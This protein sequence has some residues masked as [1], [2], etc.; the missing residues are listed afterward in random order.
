MEE[1]PS[2]PLGFEE[3]LKAPSHAYSEDSITQDLR[4]VGSLGSRTGKAQEGA[5][6]MREETG[7]PWAHLQPHEGS[8]CWKPREGLV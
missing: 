6:G 8:E 7:S 5:A 1:I 4:W 2:L 3:P